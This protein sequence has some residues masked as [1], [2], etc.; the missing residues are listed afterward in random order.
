MNDIN[1]RTLDLNLLR[2]FDALV[3]EGNATRAGERLGLTQSA[4]S[5]GLNRLR[6]ELHDELF[7]RGG[8]GM[9]PTPRA[10][11]IAPKLREGLMHLQR[12]LTAAEFDPATSERLFTLGGTSY[13]RT[14]L[15]PQVVARLRELAPRAEI[16]IHPGD[17]GVAEDLE[18][19]RLDVVFGSFG[20]VPERFETETVFEE[21]S[22]WAVSARFYA[23]IEPMDIESLAALPH[24]L[25]DPHVGEGTIVAGTIVDSGIEQRVMRDEGA[26]HAALA[27]RGLKR[28]VGLTVPDANSALIIVGQSDMATLVP[29]RLAERWAR[30]ALLKLFESPYPIPPAPVDMLWH[31]AHGAHPAVAWLRAIVREVAAGL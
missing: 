15:F 13:F 5:H 11:E 8:D 12:A 16:R 3:T 4:V 19:G 26:L 2:V 22:V 30:V 20:R 7:V 10:V 27:A 17:R 9:R 24:V 23:G 18:R 21:S 28:R 6:L 1:F 25:I 29:H 31:R 14:I